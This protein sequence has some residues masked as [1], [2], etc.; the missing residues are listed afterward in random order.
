MGGGLEVGLT[1]LALRPMSG[2]WRRSAGGRSSTGRAWSSWR[3]RSSLSAVTSRI[4]WLPWWLPWSLVVAL[5]VGLGVV[6]AAVAQSF[7]GFP[8][9]LA[10]AIGLVPMLGLAAIEPVLGLAFLPA[11]IIGVWC[12]RVMGPLVRRRG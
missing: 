12:G 10:L 7:E 9:L 3:P 4:G 1:V 5:G 2:K 6:V 8:G 11:H